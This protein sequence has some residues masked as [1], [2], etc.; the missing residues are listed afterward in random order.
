MKIECTTQQSHNE[1][2]L[3]ALKLTRNEI[4]IR[5]GMDFAGERLWYGVEMGGKMHFLASGCE[6]Y[7][8][9]ELPRGIKAGKGNV[10]G[11]P[12]SHEG[13]Q[14]YLAGEKVDGAKLL[15]ELEAYF[16]RHAKFQN[17]SLPLAMAAWV[18]A[19]YAYMA[20]PIFPYIRLTSAQRQCGKSKVLELLSEVAF[21]AKPI[22]VNPTS[23]VLFRSLHVTGQVLLLDEFENATD[24]TQRSMIAVLNS[25]FQRGAEVPRCV[26]DEYNIERFQAYSPKAFA[27]LARVPE[28]LQSRSIPVLMMP[29]VAADRIE[30]F[31]P[32]VY[33][34]RASRWRDDA[35]IWALWNAPELSRFVTGGRGDLQIPD[36]LE[37]RQ[38]D[39]MAPLFAT[40]KLTG[41]GLQGL[42]AF[43]SD[44]AGTTQ[45]PAGVGRATRAVRAL[46]K[47]FPRDEQERRLFLSEVAIML[48]DSEA[49]DEPDEREAGLMLRNLGLD[50]RQIRIGSDSKKGVCI[51]EEQMDNLVSRFLANAPPDE[52]AAA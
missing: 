32:V 30:P 39:Y 42:L 38:V 35:A 11:A 51:S 7:P 29:K 8:A 2:F 50:V 33:A 15:V 31:S 5:P 41:V 9:D 34:E 3:D 19:G 23:A 45:Q 36:Y 21:R 13:M 22:L 17:D 47:W 1:K 14:R 4:T 40:A 48:Y 49:L 37:D 10:H 20:C 28:T 24:D 18:L 27:G 26:G 12:I 52:S 6:V 25:G 43:C 46:A 16:R 44:L